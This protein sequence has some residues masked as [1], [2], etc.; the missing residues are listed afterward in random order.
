MK[1]RILSGEAGDPISTGNPLPVEIIPAPPITPINI[2]G[3][4]TTGGSAQ[5]LAP[6]NAGRKGLRFRNVSS[7]LLSVSFTGA[8]TMDRNSFPIYPGEYFETE[9]HLVPETA[10]S[11]IGATTGQEFFAEEY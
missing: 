4:I 1:V 3:A 7:A 6:A 8:A 2:S 5:Q 9:A 10:I 11:V